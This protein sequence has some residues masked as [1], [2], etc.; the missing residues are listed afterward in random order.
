MRL[1]QAR[2]TP[3]LVA[4]IIDFAGV[5]GL[6]TVAEGVEHERQRAILSRLGCSTAQGFLLS[7]PLD[8]QAVWRLI[9]EHGMLSDRSLLAGDGR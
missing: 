3:A 4:T 9:A 7:R 2:A 8:Q 5:L 6:R 1:L